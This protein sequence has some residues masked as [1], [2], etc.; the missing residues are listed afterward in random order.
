MK[1]LYST[2][3]LLFISLTINANDVKKHEKS[4]TINKEF[5]VNKNAKVS[6]SNKY[7]DV[8]VTTWTKNKVA[9]EVIITVKGNDLDDVERKLNSIDVAFE[10]GNSFV[11]AKTIFEKERSSWKFWNNNNKT[12]YKI[13]YIVK[14]PETNSVNLNNDYGSIYLDNLIGKA[15]INC[16]YGKIAVGEL[17][18]EDNSINL[19]YC[20][21]S[22]IGFMKSGAVNIDYSKL[23]I[24]ESD[25]LKI[26]ADYSTIKLEKSESVNFNTDY[27]SITIDEVTNALGNS[28]YTSM[29]FGTVKKNLKIDSDYGSISVK[30]LAK[31]FE[32]VDI[33]AQYASIR[34]GVD[35]NSVFDFNLEL[36]YAGFKRDD[37]KIE[38]YKKISK[39]TKKYYEGKFGKGNS[40]S[41]I[42]IKSQYGGVSIKEN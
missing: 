11:D 30:N 34:I 4:K 3:V 27:G 39:T 36:Q 9:I 16:D 13:N 18:A 29:R 25:V 37:D 35:A 28:D 7:G 32:L 6:I 10:S 41:R 42:K 38:F 15:S 8:K 22:T 1:L 26:N 14:M 31:D 17:A 5:T 33:D 2:I 23:T 40:N 21:S 12:N 19:D 24:E 20:S